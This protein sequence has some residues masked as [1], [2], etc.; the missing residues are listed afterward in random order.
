MA[1]GRLFGHLAAAE[2]AAGADGP[3]G[4][5]ARR[6]ARGSAAGLVRPSKRAAQRLRVRRLRILFAL[7]VAVGCLLVGATSHT[8]SA[9][10]RQLA[11]KGLPNGFLRLQKGNRTRL[12]DLTA[13]ISGCKGRLY[14]PTTRERFDVG[15]ALEVIDETTQN[16][17]TYLLLLA[18]AHPSCNVQGHCGAAPSPDATVICLDLADDLKVNGRQSFVIEDCK[19]GRSVRLKEAPSRKT[20]RFVDDVLTIEYEEIGAANEN[21]MG[22]VVYD[23][24]T[25]QVGFRTIR[26]LAK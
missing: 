8:M 2:Q 19:G 15:V 6:W 21:P 14:D 5:R 26:S 13:N 4:E 1:C 10:Q 24:N 23:R 9:E 11:I 25:P 3:I 22:Q 18:S 17:H 12:V 7:L 20:L 16:A